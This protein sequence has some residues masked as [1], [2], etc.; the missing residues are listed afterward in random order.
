VN[1]GRVAAA[2]VLVTALSVTGATINASAAAQ[3]KKIKKVAVL[4]A[5]DKKDGGFYQGQVEALQKS[6]KKNH[7]KLI[8]IDKVGIGT[9][10]E[11]F[12]NAARQKPDIIV[13]TGQELQD[14]FIAAFPPQC[15]GAAHAIADDYQAHYLAGYAAAEILKAAGK[16][17]G[18]VATVAGPQLNFVTDDNKALEAGLKADDPSAQFKIVYTGDFEDAALA[19][20]AAKAQIAQGANLLYPYLGGAL[21]A[22]VQAANEANVPVLATSIDGCNVPAGGPKFAGSVL[23]NPAPFYG[24]L[25]N[26]YV[27]GKLKAGQFFVYHIDWP[28]LGANICG[29]TPEQQQVLKDIKQKLVSGEIKVPNTPFTSTKTRA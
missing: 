26:R 29:A 4:I 9:S 11:A 16:T 6:A 25:I 21:I 24:D 2:L 3:N 17:G 5:G 14:G 19:T 22:V 18:T 12:Q 8:V 10:T 28:G 13:S 23:F 20:E 27:K 7:F 15:K 1:R